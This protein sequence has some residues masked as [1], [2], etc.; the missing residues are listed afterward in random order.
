[1]TGGEAAVECLRRR[2]VDHLFTV[3]GESFL[4]IL[5][6]LH[7]VEDIDLIAARHEQG[8]VEMAAAWSKATRRTGV[9]AATRAVGASNLTLGMYTALE[10]SVPLVAIVGQ[11]PTTVE[12][13]G[14]FQEIDLTT[15]FDRFT[16]WAVRV[17]RPERIPELLGQAFERA[18]G[19]RPG[20]VLVSLPEDVLEGEAPEP[21]SRRAITGSDAEVPSGVETTLE[22]LR[23]ADHPVVLAGGDVLRSSASD[24]LVEFVERVRVPVVSAYQRNDVFPNGH[25]QY[26]GCSGPGTAP[27]LV[28]YLERSDLVLALGTRLSQLTTQGYRFPSEEATL[29]HQHPSPDVIASSGFDAMS[30]VGDS[31]TVL[32][33][34]LRRSRERSEPDPPRQRDRRIEEVRDRIKK[35]SAP[36]ENFEV[37]QGRVHPAKVMQQLNQKLPS[38]AA[39]VVDA[40]NYYGWM[41]RICE[42]VRPGTYF[43]PTS[44]A[45]GYGIPA[46]LGV[47]AATPDRP[48]VCLTGDGG[49]MM[50]IQ[51][52]ATAVQYDLPVTVVVMNN[53]MH[54]TIRMYQEKQYPGRPVGTDLR[55]PDFVELAGSFGIEGERVEDNREVGNALQRGLDADG[56]YLIEM[57]QDPNLI[58]VAHTLEDLRGDA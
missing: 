30:L 39:L 52:L 8:A 2:N 21:G 20:P 51:E 46:A 11:V 26:L 53:E 25:P 3:P 17:P 42:F 43:G 37:K 6:A 50:V 32:E 13:R 27:A 23:R 18:R 12:G 45:M 4:P 35:Q 38:E 9:C 36:P 54:G 16:K 58:S 24:R 22:R 19:G 41:V 28:D 40:G 48:V 31:G 14:G 56:S 34:L 47:K 44:G 15:A 29:I 33:S 7:D 57:M 10:D 5:D 49:S 55:N 1:M